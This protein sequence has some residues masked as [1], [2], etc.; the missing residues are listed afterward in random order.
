MIQVQ[1]EIN[2]G[3]E[4][5]DVSSIVDSTSEKPVSAIAE[6]FKADNGSGGSER[7]KTQLWCEIFFMPEAAVYESYSSFQVFW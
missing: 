5:V 1:L 3:L 7:S 6:I 4:E 2:R